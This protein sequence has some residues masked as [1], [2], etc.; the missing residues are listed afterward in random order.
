METKP[1][2]PEMRIMTQQGFSQ[3]ILELPKDDAVLYMQ[4][5]KRNGIWHADV[6]DYKENEKKMLLYANS[7][8]NDDTLLPHK[9]VT[10]AFR[11]LYDYSNLTF[12]Q[13]DEYISKYIASK[14]GVRL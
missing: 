4:L 11:Y 13:I 10:K 5:L 14:Q 8:L 1:F 12:G 3:H 2:I 7:I 9:R 6:T